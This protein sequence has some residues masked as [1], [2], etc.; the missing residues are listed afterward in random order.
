METT[1]KQNTQTHAITT[2]TTDNTKTNPFQDLL[3]TLARETDQPTDTSTY[4]KALSDTAAAIAYTVLKKCIAVSQNKA[5]IQVR[6]SIARDLH[7]LDRLIYANEHAYEI[8]YN[9]DGDIE[10]RVKD[11]DLAK[12]LD[13]LVKECFGDG[14]D[15]VNDAVLAILDQFAKQR[16]REPD[17]AADL[18]RPYTVRRLN[19]KVWI[20]TDDSVNGWETVETTPIQEIFKAVRRSIDSSRAVQT[21]PRNG[22]TYLQDL[23][24]DTDSDNAETMYRRM[25]KYADIG[26][27]A[28]DFN[29]AFT[30]YTADTETVKDIDTLVESL[31]LTA[32]QARVLQLR[33]S[34]YGYKAIATYLGV[35][36][37]A[38]AK[39]VQA[40]QDKAFGI[41]LTPTK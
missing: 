15:L 4:T 2:A 28:T 18:A 23:A 30:F 35:T 17:Q 12:V 13:D 33:Q 1:K 37:R 41:G 8:V 26:G 27:Y 31:N 29:G 9:S 11:K 5:L 10:K 3:D 24:H 32:K 21:D 16:E 34:G 7:N 39:T 19:R 36:Q 38:I 22:Y 6:Q 20:K 25:P 40:I 14:L